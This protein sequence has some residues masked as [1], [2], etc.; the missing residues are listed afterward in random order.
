MLEL[1]FGVATDRGVRRAV[2]EDRALA[3]DGI[4][5]VADGMGG[6]AAGDVAS[7][8][9]IKALDRLAHTRAPRSSDDLATA[10]QE[11]NQWIL[12]AVVDHPDHTGMGTTITGVVAASIGGSDHWVV[13]NVGDSRVYQFLEGRLRQVTVDHSEIEELI[14]AGSL[15]PAEARDDP[16]RNIVTRSLGTDP[17]PRPDIWVFPPTPGERFLVCSDGLTDELSDDE[18]QGFLCEGTDAQRV[19]DELVAAAVTA[20]GRDNV[21][22]IVVDVVISSG[23]SGAAVDTAPRRDQK[24]GPPVG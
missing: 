14:A 18:I 15:T 4:A 23:G 2:N 10:I 3:T 11:A 7:G 9:A 5:V 21:T 17:P 16:R 13:F 20:G 19:A 12:D 6:H 8:I 1:A 22:A 24:P